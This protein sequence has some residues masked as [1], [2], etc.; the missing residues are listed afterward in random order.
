MTGFVPKY[1]DIA[2]MSKLGLKWL[3][4]QP[5]GIYALT[6]CQPKPALDLVDSLA[7]TRSKRFIVLTTHVVNGHKW[8]RLTFTIT[9]NQKVVYELPFDL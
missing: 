3:R 4:C 9:E 8:Q 7:D 5:D 6:N 1:A 2:M